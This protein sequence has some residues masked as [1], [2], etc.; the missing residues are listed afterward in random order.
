MMNALMGMSGPPQNALMQKITPTTLGGNMQ[1]GGGGF[2][3]LN[4]NPV[5]FQINPP[6]FHGWQHMPAFQHPWFRGGWGGGPINHQYN[7]WA[8]Y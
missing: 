4:P 3:A 2:A 8:R 6:Q 1:I 7:G 5:Q